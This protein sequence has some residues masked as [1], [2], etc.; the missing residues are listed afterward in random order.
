MSK[1]NFAEK[2]CSLFD[3]KLDEKSK[4]S[5][6]VFEYNSIVY[7]AKGGVGY[8]YQLRRFAN[9]FVVKKANKE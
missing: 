2:L 7:R 9:Y 1:S 6:L 4:V 8:R 3:P 5:F